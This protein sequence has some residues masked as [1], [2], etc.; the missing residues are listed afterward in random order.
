M[1]VLLRLYDVRMD[2][3]IG[4][5]DSDARVVKARLDTQDE[6]GWSGRGRGH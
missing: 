3:T 4:T 5:D 2:G 6:E 1:P